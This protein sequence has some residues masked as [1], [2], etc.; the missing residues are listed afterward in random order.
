MAA[1]LSGCGKTDVCSSSCVTTTSSSGRHR[2]APPAT[3]SGGRSPA[4]RAVPVRA[5]NV[6]HLGLECQPR[7]AL[8]HRPVDR[9]RR[10]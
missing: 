7:L 6:F 3:V 10:R 8:A 9:N 5:R 1:A 4:V 2:A